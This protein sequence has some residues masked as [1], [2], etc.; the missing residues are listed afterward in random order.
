MSLQVA[1]F[2][3]R[4]F[5]DEIAHIRSELVILR[6]SLDECLV[7]WRDYGFGEV[8]NPVA[9]SLRRDIKERESLLQ[10]SE[11]ALFNMMQ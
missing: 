2:E 9:S 7:S 5:Q 10:N 1:H 6:R 3:R 11:L 8:S 4:A